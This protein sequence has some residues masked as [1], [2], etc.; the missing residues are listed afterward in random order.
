MVEEIIDQ[1]Q[2]QE[3]VNIRT[4]VPWTKLTTLGV[5]KTARFVIEP[6][7]EAGLQKVLQLCHAN[8]VSV[9]IL[10]MGSNIVGADN[11]LDEVLIKLTRNCM[12]SIMIEGSL[13]TAGAT[14]GNNILVKEALVHGLGG[15]SP[16][17]FIPGELGGSL[18]MNA[19]AHGSTISDYLVELHGFDRTG[20]LLVLQKSDV[21]WNYRSSSLAEDFLITKA[22]FDLPTVDKDT[23]N[24]KLEK[25]MSIR[26]E[27]NAK[28]RSAGCVFKNPS[29]DTSAGRLIDQCG[30][31]GMAVG[32]ALV[33]SDHA[34][35]FVNT[36]QATEN[37]FIS[38]AIQVKKR[39]FE[40]T[41]IYLQP[42]VE[43]VNP[44]SAEKL[45]KTSSTIA[46]LKGGTSSERDVSLESGAA[47][48]SALRSAGYTVLEV[49]IK[50]LE[51][52]P[53]M[54]QADIV[55]P[56]LHGGFGENG[57]LQKL[58]EDNH[59]EFVGCGSKACETIMDKISS[60]QV[61]FDHGIKGAGDV[62]LTEKDYTFPQTMSLP[63]VTKPPKDGSSFG[64]SLVTT[65]EEWKAALDFSYTY[66]NRLLVEEYI[67]GVELTVG[68]IDGEPLP[69]VEIDYPGMMY[70]F[71]AKYTHEQGVTHYHCPPQNISNEIH[72]QCQQTAVKFFK[73]VEARDVTR[74]D[75][76]VDK[77]NNIYVLE[78]NN[79]P[80]F[81][82]SSL[83]P[84]SAKEAGQSFVQ[85]CA[86]LALCAI[87][88]K[89]SLSK[90]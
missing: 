77:K 64:V 83:L 66:D 6:E 29:E 76:M 58:M 24:L 73:A 80:G 31:K 70:D 33:S 89:K 56:V 60:K 88:R 25:L 21:E 42:E 61:M 53:E 72:Q 8:K 59:I 62:I 46:V 40:K 90:D 9:C 34:N 69:A 57:Q 27:T 38:L 4:D 18:R 26:K 13:L 68:V 39:V 36:G 65:M 2:G 43:F 86:R 19:G 47:V 30:C 10:G 63:V 50:A 48:A 51:I 84:K 35:F 20:Q 81:T 49:D 71:D 14:V 78:G 28:G 75:I 52:T 23:E 54:R 22:I 41:G 82:A 1:L 74:V 11:A 3:A 45:A 67:D 17:A 87:K 44:K 15:I 32:D 5:G 79:L 55:F 12:N 7:S 37:D 16:L 85:L